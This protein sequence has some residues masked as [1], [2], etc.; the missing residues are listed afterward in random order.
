MKNYI[1]IGLALLIVFLFVK[2]KKQVQDALA[3]VKGSVLPAVQTSDS[4][5]SGSV[6]LNTVAPSGN[7][8]IVVSNSNSSGSDYDLATDFA[9]VSGSVQLV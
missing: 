9:P 3:K 8:T 5:P 4:L 2:N 1:L 7:S 6:Q